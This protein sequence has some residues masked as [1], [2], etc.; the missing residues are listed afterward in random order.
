MT[1]TAIF[2]AVSELLSLLNI[3]A[4]WWISLSDEQRKN[5]KAAFTEVLNADDTKKPG[6]MRHASNRFLDTL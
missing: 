3:G 5:V 2:K 6:S 4:K 1:V